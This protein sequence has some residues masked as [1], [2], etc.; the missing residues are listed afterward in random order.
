MK[1]SFTN[2]SITLISIGLLF[3]LVNCGSP[4]HPGL[5]SDSPSDTASASSTGAVSHGVATGD[6]TSDA[7]VIWLRT[8]GPAQVEVRFA[9]VNW[10]ERN[11]NL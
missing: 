10:E 9:P 6:V 5:R 7:A 3:S 4:S 8:N 1:S 2:L 11:N